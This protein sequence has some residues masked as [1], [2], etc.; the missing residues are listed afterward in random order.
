[1]I[2]SVTDHIRDHLL[3]L[4]E[5]EIVTYD[6]LCESEWSPE[7]EQYM[8][9]RLMMGALRY[10]RLRIEGKPHYNRVHRLREC[11]IDYEAT[12]NLE[13][14][15]DVANLA[16][17]EFVEGKHAQRHFKAVD[18]GPHAKV[19]QTWLNQSR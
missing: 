11:L 14:L 19:K 1:M 6:E 5:L 15:V 13:C 2:K 12:G 17:V 16:L 9:N 18:D 8:R 10:G 3:G 7:F 4:P